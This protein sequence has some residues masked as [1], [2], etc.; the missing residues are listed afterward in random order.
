LPV[1]ARIRA[2]DPRTITM[3]PMAR[4]S[5]SPGTAFVARGLLL[6]L[7]GRLATLRAPAPAGADERHQS[8]RSTCSWPRP[9]VVRLLRW[10]HAAWAHATSL[11]KVTPGVGPPVS[12]PCGASGGRLAIALVATTA[13]VVVPFAINGRR[14]GFR[15]G[16]GCSVGASFP[17]R[18]RTAGI[19]TCRSASGLAE[20]ARHRDRPGESRNRPPLAGGP[21]AGRARD[22]VGVDQFTHD[23]GLAIIPASSPPRARDPAGRWLRRGDAKPGSGGSIR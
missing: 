14:L 12:S 3:L 23:P 16:W 2:R 17:A 7:T 10:A 19:S 15:S 1:L 20:T 22:A 11:T 5:R 13:L 21:L 9:S 18:P 8:A 6:W 4:F